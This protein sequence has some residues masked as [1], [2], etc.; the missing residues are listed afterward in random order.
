MIKTNQIDGDVNSSGLSVG[1]AEVTSRDS[2]R[3][4]NAKLGHV[5]QNTFPKGISPHFHEV[6]G[7]AFPI[8]VSK[9]QRG[10]GGWTEP[11]F[12]M[13]DVFV[14]LVVVV[15]GAGLVAKLC[16]TLTTPRTVAFQAPLSLGFPR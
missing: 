2:K 12:G 9:E 15:A 4:G 11:S 3:N 8:T 16:P 13:T 14:V 1:T 7:Y 6:Y 5:D 10:T